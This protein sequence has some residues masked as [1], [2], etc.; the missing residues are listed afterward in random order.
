[1]AD[2]TCTT[3]LHGHILA[4][5]AGTSFDKILDPHLISLH[6]HSMW[7]TICD[8]VASSSGINLRSKPYSP[9]KTHP[10]MKSCQIWGT[11][12]LT[13]P[14]Y[15]LSPEKWKVVRFGT[16]EREVQGARMWGLIYVFPAD[17]ISLWLSVRKGQLFVTHCVLSFM[18][19]S[20]IILYLSFPQTFNSAAK[21]L[22]LWWF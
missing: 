13:C 14:E 16:S 22:L 11:L 21:Y 15:P 3:L 7:E 17:T 19:Q 2:S 10:Q 18:V 8:A 20:D 12:D 5:E 4:S 9:Q 1:M 6:I